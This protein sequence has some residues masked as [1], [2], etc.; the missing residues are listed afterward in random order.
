[1]NGD[2]TCSAPIALAP[3]ITVRRLNVLVELHF[4]IANPP[5]FFHRL[6]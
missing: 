3:L 4:D 2:V 6:S 1:M 5:N